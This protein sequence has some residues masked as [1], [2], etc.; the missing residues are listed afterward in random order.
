MIISH[1]EMNEYLHRG[2]CLVKFMKNDGDERMMACTLKKELM[3]N[4]ERK[5]QNYQTGDRMIVWDLDK[6]AFRS[7]KL[8]SVIWVMAPEKE[9]E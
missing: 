3:P 8:N 4:Y 2:E 9:D 7:F 5:T 6:E 1:D